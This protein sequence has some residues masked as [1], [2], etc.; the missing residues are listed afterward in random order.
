MD[1]ERPS[2]CACRFGHHQPVGE[3]RRAINRDEA[4][5]YYRLGGQTLGPVSWAEIEQITTDTVPAEDLL[6]ARG[7]DEGWLSAA[8]VVE[9]HPELA[10]QAEPEPSAAAEEVIG[11][12]GDD[13][14][15]GG[16]E[17]AMPAPHEPEEAA[18]GPHAAVS[19]GFEPKHGLG[20]WIGQAWEMVTGELWPW[21]GATLLLMLLGT[22]TLGICAPP[23]LVGLYRMALDRFAGREIAPGDVFQGFSYFL[24]A[25]GLALLMMLPALLVMAPIMIM[26]M[27]PVIAADG[28]EEIGVGVMLF[29]QALIPVLWL[30]LMAVQTI[31]FYSYVLVAEGRGAWDAVIGSWEKVRENFFSYLMMFLL[32]S[33]L[34]GIGSNL[35]GVGILVTYPLLPCAQ[36][37]AYRWHF[38]RA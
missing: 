10:V 32:L 20:Q 28:G 22:V 6:V 31:F 25:W 30:L 35:C 8:E 18:P 3:E 1:G 29:M 23:L 4:V 16:P 11:E 19:V 12:A 5:W 37:A 26:F 24:N 2:R 21:I 13:R 17:E 7:G 14:A 38:R 15:A 27:I 34:S 9:Q 36:V 33:I